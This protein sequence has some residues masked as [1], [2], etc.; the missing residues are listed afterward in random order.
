M[1]LRRILVSCIG[2]NPIIKIVVKSTFTKNKKIKFFTKN[3]NCYF[4]LFKL[5]RLLLF[6]FCIILS[7]IWQEHFFYKFH[8]IKQFME[9]LW[10]SYFFILSYLISAYYVYPILFSDLLRANTFLMIYIPIFSTTYI[11]VNSLSWYDKK[12]SQYI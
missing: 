9:Q 1:I 8:F 12:R 5:V 3:T 7:N 10:N 4:L 11:L 2:Q 6:I